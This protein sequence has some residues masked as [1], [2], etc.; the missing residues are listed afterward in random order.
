MQTEKIVIHSH[1]SSIFQDF[2]LESPKDWTQG[3]YKYFPIEL[4]PQAHKSFL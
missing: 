2:K 4:W 3:L 1:K